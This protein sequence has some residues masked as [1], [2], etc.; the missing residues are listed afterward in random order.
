ML[1]V[2]IHEE[3]RE[4]KPMLACEIMADGDV[5]KL[6]EDVGRVILTVYANIKQR[7]PIAADFFKYAMQESMED[8]A[9]WA[10]ENEVHAGEGV[11]II[12]SRDK[13]K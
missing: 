3:Q 4:G 8:P 12:T 2:D 6:C 11:S 1:K 13:K 5:L 10:M 9:F 7:I